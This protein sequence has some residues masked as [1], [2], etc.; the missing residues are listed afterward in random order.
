MKTKLISINSN[1][2]TKKEKININVSQKISFKNSQDMLA[3]I[4]ELVRIYNCNVQD[5]EVIEIRKNL[6]FIDPFVNCSEVDDTTKIEIGIVPEN[7]TDNEFYLQFTSELK[8][9]D[10]IHDLNKVLLWN[11]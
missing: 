10:F 6:S 1:R 4:R 11:T 3:H 8:V 7:D 2:T 5:N 9:Q